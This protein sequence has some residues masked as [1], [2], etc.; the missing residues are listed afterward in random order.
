MVIL[1]KIDCRL[2]IV[3]EFASLVF[4]LGQEVPSVTKIWTIWPS[5]CIIFNY[6]K[7][8]LPLGTKDSPSKEGGS[9]KKWFEARPAP[10]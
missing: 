7:D 5:Q 6:L 10:A 8:F 4:G 3:K 2:V 9:E 1:N